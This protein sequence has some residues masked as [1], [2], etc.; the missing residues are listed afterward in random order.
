[1]AEY[2]SHSYGAHQSLNVSQACKPTFP[3]QITI[4]APYMH[5][6]EAAHLVRMIQHALDDLN[7]FSAHHLRLRL[8][9]TFLLQDSQNASMAVTSDVYAAGSLAQ[10]EGMDILDEEA[11]T[12]R[13]Q[14][15]TGAQ[16]TRAELQ[17]HSTRLDVLY[18]S[19]QAPSVSSS[20]ST[21]ANFVASKLQELFAEE[22]AIIAYVLQ[23]AQTVGQAPQI[24]S[25]A[26]STSRE[27]R[28]RSQRSLNPEL[29]ARLDSHMTRSLK[30]APT[31]HITVSLFTPSAA[32]SSWEIESAL[33]EYFTPLLN[34]IS[35]VSNF[36]VDTQVQ[37][38]ATFSP[39]VHSPEYDS[40]QQIWTLREEDLS[41]FINA[42]EWPLSPSIGA[43]PTLNFVLYVPD[44]ATSP[45]VVKES[46]A[47]SWLIPQW[48]GVV[49][50]NPQD[51]NKTSNTATLSKES[52]QPALLTF[53]HQLLSF[54]GAPQTPPSLPLQM[55]TLTRIRAASLL[56]SASA[57]MGSLARL[58]VALPSIAIPETVSS[59][60]DI[61]LMHLR[62]TCDALKEGK[63]R[64]ALENA[65]IAE[66]Q[67]EKGFFEK[68]MVGQVYFPDEHKVAV[69]LPLLGP[70]G[71]PLVM[72]ALKELRRLWA[73]RK[74]GQPG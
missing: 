8:A 23:P 40:E 62:T 7:E 64:D 57:T 1:M 63:F 45:L 65:R 47:S 33:T 31:Y 60:V 24:S 12:V 52:I 56:L 18:A 11:L 55:Q 39:S 16:A 51:A 5:E 9:K 41:G 46:R 72:S 68:S 28:S 21:L 38:Y 15:K 61:T 74:A 35:R 3:L 37:L 30:Y 53:S 43:G 20:S 27:L 50:L 25:S 22:Q 13:L 49:I 26:S 36:T 19:N 17:S 14:P 6:P 66:I 54:L 48:G 34:S 42:A 73:S 59:A 44:R 69:Y 71:V 29:A 32:P 70:V 58:T 67:A 2:L 10:Y 4:E